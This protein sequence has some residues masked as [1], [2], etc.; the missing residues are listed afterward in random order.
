MNSNAP[1]SDRGKWAW[2]SIGEVLCELR[3]AQGK[4]RDDVASAAGLSC[5]G[6][7]LIETGQSSGGS[8]LE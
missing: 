5:N 2:E 8:L 6:L 3:E 4:T 1:D 7:H